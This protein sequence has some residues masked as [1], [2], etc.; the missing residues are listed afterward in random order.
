VKGQPC[1][2]PSR[3]YST[4][5]RS[6]FV[7]P[8]GGLVRGR[9][10]AGETLVVNGATGAYGSGA[11]LVALTMGAGRVVAAGRSADKL[12]RLVRLAG[13][14]V[15][16]VVLSGDMQK[17]AVALREAAGGGAEIV[18]DM[19]GGASER[20]STL[21]ALN[22]LRRAGCDCDCTERLSLG[23]R[24]RRLQAPTVSNVP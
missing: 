6:G 7:V 22:S 11:V 15:V 9:L 12:E 20:S 4:S 1:P 3:L 21:A 24:W 10:A 19:V 2:W 13:K 14:A 8:Y 5:L 18:F 16:P 23:R 17:D